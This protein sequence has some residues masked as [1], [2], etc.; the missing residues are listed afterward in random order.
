MVLGIPLTLLLTAT[1]LYVFDGDF[2]GKS[3]SGVLVGVA[4]C[5]R[6]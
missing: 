4:L 5:L 3:I 6:R 1:A 2:V